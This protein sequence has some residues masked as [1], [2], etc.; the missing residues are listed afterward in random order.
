MSKYN[1]GKFSA[2]N[3]CPVKSPFQALFER[4]FS[5]SRRSVAGYAM[6]KDKDTERKET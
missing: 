4:L 1:R 5:T 6:S 2:N 3:L